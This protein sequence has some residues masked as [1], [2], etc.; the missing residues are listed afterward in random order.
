MERDSSG[1]IRMI[2]DSVTWEKA[3]RHHIYVEVLNLFPHPVAVLEHHVVSAIDSTK[4]PGYKYKPRSLSALQSRETRN[5]RITANI[6][7]RIRFHLDNFDTDDYG[8]T[9]TVLLTSEGTL[10]LVPVRG[11]SSSIL[12]CEEVG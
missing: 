6:D 2:Q 4:I 12:P 7:R 5:F 9:Q 11:I 1:V 8:V 3:Q 10:P